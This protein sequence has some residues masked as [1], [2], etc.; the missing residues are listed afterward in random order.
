MQLVNFWPTDDLNK[1][2]NLKN[3][4]EARMALVDVAATLEDNLLNQEEVRQQVQNDINYRDQQLLRLKDEVIE[5]EDTSESVSLTEFTLDDFRMDLNRYIEANR[6]LLE[7]APLGLYA[8]VP[9]DPQ[10]EVIQPGVIFCL[11][12]TGDTSGNE[13]VN[14]LQ[15]YYLVYIRDDREVRFTFAQPKQILEMFRTLCSGVTQPYESLCN[16]FDA[17]TQNGADMTYYNELLLRAVRSIVDTFRRRTAQALT[18]GREGRLVER[19]KQVSEDSDFELV[20]WL[21]IK[22]VQ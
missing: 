11:R 5:L 22:S 13:K 4:V 3:R 19:S 15:P 1:Y 14:P 20:T 18:S 2:I 8:V 21:V 17:E 9:P 10:H 12:Q 6:K 16:L 7:D